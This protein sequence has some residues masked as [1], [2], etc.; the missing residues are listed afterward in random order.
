MTNPIVESWAKQDKHLEQSL[1][2]T[3]GRSIRHQ[4]NSVKDKRF[5][6]KA[7]RIRYALILS[8]PDKPTQPSFDLHRIEDPIF[9]GKP[10][11]LRIFLRF[12]IPSAGYLLI[13]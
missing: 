10:E 3:N 9:S 13:G 7:R 5:N 1:L 12:F 8:V 6:P 2:A 11:N 4:F